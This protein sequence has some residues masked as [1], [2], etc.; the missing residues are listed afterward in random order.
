MDL[1]DGPVDD[2][3]VVATRFSDLWAA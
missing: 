1:L 2:D 3:Q